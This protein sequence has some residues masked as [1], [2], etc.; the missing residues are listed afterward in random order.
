MMRSTSAGMIAGITVFFT[1]YVTPA[2]SEGFEPSREPLTRT[3]RSITPEALTERGLT[4]GVYEG[5]PTVLADPEKYVAQFYATLASNRGEPIP[6]PE[7]PPCDEPQPTRYDAEACRLVNSMY[8]EVKDKAQRQRYRD[9]IRRGRDVWFKGTFGNQDYFALHVGKGLYGEVRYPDQ[10]HWLDTRKRDDRYRLWGMINDPDCEQGD[11]ST[12]WLDRCDD[13]KSSGVVGLRKYIN[14]NPPE[15]FDPFRTPYQ[16]GELAD[17]RRFVIGQACAVCHVAFDPTNPPADPNKPGWENLTGHIGNQYTNNTMQFFGNLPADHFA[18]IMYN[19]IEVGQVDT[20][21]GH[22]DFVY[23][24]GTQNNITD[25]QNRPIFEEDIKHPITGEVTRAKTR[26]VLKGGE[27]SVGEKLALMR[28]YLNIGLCFAECTEDK[29]AKPGAFFGEGS[30]HKPFRIKQC[31]QACE[32]WNQAEAKMDEMALYLMAGGPFYLR[33][34]VDVD[35]RKG[36]TFINYDKVPRGR[37]V[38]ARECASCHST[39]TPPATIRSDKD[40]LEEFYAGHVFG[41]EADWQREV[42]KQAASDFKKRFFKD[43]RPRQFAEHDVFGQD[44][45]GNDELTPHDELGVNRCRSMHGNQIQGAVWEEFSSETYKQRPAPGTDYAKTVTPLLPVIGG[46]QAFGG[47]EEI[48]GGRGYYRNVSLLSIWSHA[49]FLH[50]NTLGPLRKLADGS[51]DYTVK[52][53]ISMFEDAMAQMLMSDDPQVHP[54]RELKITRVPLDTKLPTKVG[55][56]PKIK[57]AAGTPVVE[58]LS[59]NPHSPLHL[60]CADYVENKGHTFGF[61]LPLADKQAL[62]EFLKTL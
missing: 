61:E 54:H 23:N 55:G 6:Q 8:T 38:Y 62:I 41:R 18:K 49:P 19:A 48:D 20:T 42:G 44:W 52:G 51:I 39:R 31:Y 11:E 1:T 36:E 9:I 17:S 57:V 22:M 45:L 37:T 16:E 3:L 47:N 4:T 12:Y 14:P 59:L 43:G 2:W 56:E 15:G 26:H 5:S 34:A 60:T 28:V 32:P 35:G 13:P 21:S 33:D 29:F 50:N 40:A 53:R 30:Y 24:P 27:D 46:M 58:I 10:S 7:P 25:F